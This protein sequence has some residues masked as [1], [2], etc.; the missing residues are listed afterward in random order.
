VLALKGYQIRG[1]AGIDMP[2]N[3]IALHPGLSPETVRDIVARAKARAV[4]FVTTILSG[5]RRLTGSIASLL[6]LLVLP[7]SLG[8][9]LIGRFY[10]A[11]LLFASHHCTGCA[12]CAKH[13]P[14]RAIEMRG[15]GKHARP[16]WTFRC[17]SCMRCM[18]YCP[19]NAVEASHLLA[20]GTYLLAGGIPTA[21]AVAWLAARVPLLA[22]LSRTPHWL[23]FWGSAVFAIGPLYW[24]FHLLLRVKWVNRFFSCATLTHYYRRYHEP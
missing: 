20:V 16:Y 5:G 14:N 23:L 12:L 13:C 11:K 6:R 19:V 10:L 21:A 9:L 1:T 18:A 8:Y 17:E 2:S 7:I 24:L 22:P 3:W 4:P 15:R